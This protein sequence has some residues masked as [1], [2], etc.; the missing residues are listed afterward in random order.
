M[1]G[2][3]DLTDFNHSKTHKQRENVSYHWSMKTGE[4]HGLRHSYEVNNPKTYLFGGKKI[5][6]AYLL[7]ET[8]NLTV[9]ETF[10]FSFCFQMP[11]DAA[12]GINFF[13]PHKVALGIIRGV[14]PL[15]V[16]FSPG[17]LQ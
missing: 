14:W 7:C 3:T 2:K 4:D 16:F 15:R 10:N 13:V 12:I 11:T 6:K 5:T 17:T 8:Q 1:I 9:E